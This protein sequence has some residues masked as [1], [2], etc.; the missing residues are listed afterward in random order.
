MNELERKVFYWDSQIKWWESQ[1]ELLGMASSPG[2]LAAYDEAVSN[3]KD[4]RA[5]FS[6]TYQ[7][8]S[9]VKKQMAGI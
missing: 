8:W 9:E 5:N 4:A 2:G 7:S 6:K 3:L 1:T